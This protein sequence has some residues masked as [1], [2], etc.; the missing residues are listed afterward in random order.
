MGRNFKT[1]IVLSLLL[2]NV[3]SSCCNGGS[4]PKPPKPVKEKKEKPKKE[5]PEKKPKKE[6]GGA[7][8]EGTAAEAKEKDPKSSGKDKKEEK[9]KP[10]PV[11]VMKPHTQSIL[12]FSFSLFHFI[13]CS[14]H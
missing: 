11:Q 4:N 9:A 14:I 8:A 6:K 7:P 5:K 13:I 1:F 10:I 3:E 12:F 2:V